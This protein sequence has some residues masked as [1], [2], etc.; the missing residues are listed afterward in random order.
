VTVDMKRI[1]KILLR[2][3]PRDHR[4][5]FAAEMFHAFEQAM[6]DRREQRWPVWVCFAF[7]EWVGLLMG[8]ATE[9]I[10]RFASRSPMR[11]CR[12]ALSGT[13]PEADCSSVPKEVAE[14][15]KRVDLLVSRIV[16][17]IANHDFAGARSY[18][19]EED[20]QRESL[21]VLRKKYDLSE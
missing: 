9:W 11:E 15:Q 17:A 8:A 12:P 19:Y 18:S 3:Y 20:V 6:D 21:R 10:W 14:A 5:R 1:Y 13:G 16:H 4:A 7:W 2:L